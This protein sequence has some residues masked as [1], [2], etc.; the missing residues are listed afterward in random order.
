MQGS[1]KPGQDPFFRH[2]AR[3]YSAPDETAAVIALDSYE[4]M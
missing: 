1:V 4:I 3:R 2:K